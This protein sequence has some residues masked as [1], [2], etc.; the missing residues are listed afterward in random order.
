M[1]DNL[2]SFKIWNEEGKPDVWNND[3]PVVVD[4]MT[5]IATQITVGLLKFYDPNSPEQAELIVED[6][7]RISEQILIQREKWINE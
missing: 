1:S 5:Q 3:N 6:A 4:R 2:S 7:F